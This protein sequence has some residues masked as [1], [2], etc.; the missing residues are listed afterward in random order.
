MCILCQQ[1]LPKRSF[2]NRNMTSNC[3]ATNSAHLMKTTIICHFNELPM[4]IFCTRNCL[5]VAL[6]R[7]T[8]QQKN[9][10]CKQVKRQHFHLNIRAPIF[11]AAT[12]FH[13]MSAVRNDATILRSNERM[14]G[15]RFSHWPSSCTDMFLDS[16]CS[17]TWETVSLRF[18]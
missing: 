12:L 8:H 3:D 5:Q 16:C 9:L 14:P 10:W 11:D 7:I 4:K 1:S 2:G 18:C 17:G 15:H 13:P 6:L